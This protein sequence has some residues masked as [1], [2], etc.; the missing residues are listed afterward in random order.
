MD[1]ENRVLLQVTAEDATAADELF[2]KLMGDDVAPRRRFIQ[3]NA[4]EV[5]NIDIA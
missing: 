4:L 5:K 3:T 1:P 2:R